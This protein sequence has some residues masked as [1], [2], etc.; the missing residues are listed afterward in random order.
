MQSFKMAPQL[1]LL[2]RTT[3]ICK[4]LR[5]TN[6]RVNKTV[7]HMLLSVGCPKK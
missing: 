1:R 4:M 7:A 3:A 5:F 2:I 6:T